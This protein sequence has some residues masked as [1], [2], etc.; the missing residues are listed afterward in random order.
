MFIE[1]WNNNIK[2]MN[3]NQ[4]ANCRGPEEIKKHALIQARKLIKLNYL[5]QLR[6]V[7]PDNVVA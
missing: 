1:V 2:I 4:I 7:E 5:T 3:L 6:F